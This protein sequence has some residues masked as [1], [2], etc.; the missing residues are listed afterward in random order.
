[1]ADSKETINCGEALTIAHVATI[2]QQ[3]RKALE[4]SST[5]E[6]VADA[7]EKVDTAG[8]Q[9]FVALFKE[10]EKVG[11]H[12]VWRS[13]SNVLTDAAATLGLTSYLAFDDH[14]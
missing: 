3:L 8:L 12:V 7:V 6:V 4:K 9:L 11:G 5:I 10:L 1:M 14:A 13:P 2:N